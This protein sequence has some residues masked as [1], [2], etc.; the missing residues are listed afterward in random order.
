MAP[1]KDFVLIALLKYNYFPAHKKEKEELPPIFSTKQFTKKIAQK[2]SH[3]RSRKDGYDQI[4]YKITRYNNI[5]RV[6]SIPH[7]KPYAD[8]VFCLSENWDNLAYICNNE[9]SLIRPRQH[10]DG[11]IIIMNYEGSHEK[12]ERSLKKSF[13][14][15]FCIETDI[16]NCFPSIYSH[17]IP[18]ALI[19]LKEA[20]SRKRY[21]NEWFNKIDARQRMLKRNET[22][23][24][25]IGP[26]SSNI[27]TEIILAKV[28]EVMSKDF[29]YIRFIDDY[30]CY[31]KKYEDAEEFARRLSQEL[32]KYN[33][34]LNLKK[35]HIHQLPKPT[36]DDWIIDLKSRISGDSKKITHYQAVNYIDYAV[37]LNKKIPD[38]SILKYAFKSIR[39]RLNV[40][41]ERFCLNYILLLAPHYPILIPI[42]NK[43]LHNASKKD[44]FVYEKELKYILDESIVNHRSDGMCWTLYY[45]LKNKVTLSPEIAKHIIATK[46]CMAILMLYLFKKFDT[47]INGFAN[48][49]DKTDL[50][51]LDNYWL[52]LY[53]LF[54]DNKIK[55]PYK[56]E[57]TFKILKDN[58]VNFIQSK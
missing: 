44:K 50:Y 57:E 43:M 20:K 55:N 19:G 2:L 52:L 29:N 32:S 56:D 24:V 14:H 33:L 15:K 8:I 23:G 11:R 39:G 7:P 37:S 28:D 3:L 22:Q 42:I 54:Y 47:E 31:C 27:I 4:S 53:Q 51:G 10:K 5:P 40:K 41:D 46:D 9:V 1:D 34:T 49:L 30:T 12:I 45:L 35:T 48:G 58:N 36:N 25:P 26:A 6:L 21:K 18:W 17:A 13:G 16:T 38:G